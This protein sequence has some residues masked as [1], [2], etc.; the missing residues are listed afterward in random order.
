MVLQADFGRINANSQY[1][2]KAN[3]LKVEEKLFKGHAVQKSAEF[4]HNCRPK[5]EESFEETP[6]LVAVITYIGYGVLVCFGYFRDLLRYYG[7]EK[8]KSA[9]EKGNEVGQIYDYFSISVLP[10]ALQQREGKPLGNSMYLFC[11]LSNRPS[12]K[13]LILFAKHRF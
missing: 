4:E 2:I 7:F 8:N 11:Q 5:V 13:S 1:V 6:L 9:K 3:D 12:M 10:V